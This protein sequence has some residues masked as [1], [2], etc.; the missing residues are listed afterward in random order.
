MYV[1]VL[2][3]HIYKEAMKEFHNGM[4]H[5]SFERVDYC[6][7]WTIHT[8]NYILLKSYNTFIGAIEKSTGTM[9]DVLR[10]VYGY[11]ATSAK[12]I[13]KFRHVFPIT[14]EYTA[15]PV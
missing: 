8:D 4:Y 15:R 11:T 1:N 10:L 6:Q 13:S 9:V 3:M 2:A 7:A 12:H 5:N 14:K